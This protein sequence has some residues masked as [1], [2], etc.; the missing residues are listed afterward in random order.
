MH[1]SE[2]RAATQRTTTITS[3]LA[4]GRAHM[5]TLI[6]SAVVFLDGVVEA[7]GEVARLNEA[8]G[9]PIPGA[10]QRDTRERTGRPLQP[11]GLS[12]APVRRKSLFSTVAK[13][14]QSLT[15]T[16]HEAY[17]NSIQKMIFDMVWPANT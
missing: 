4:P 9:G 17:G 11:A 1:S 2:R 14:A 3:P 7:P 10:G 8:E 13:D 15:L 16:E 12:D 5:R 6:I